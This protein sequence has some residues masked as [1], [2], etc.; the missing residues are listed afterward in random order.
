MDGAGR[1]GASGGDPV[2]G[3]EGLMAV[4]R[5]YLIRNYL[6]Y[7][8]GKRQSLEPGRTGPAIVDVLRRTRH[9]LALRQRPRRRDMAAPVDRDR[10]NRPRQRVP[11]AVSRSDDITIGI[12]QVQAL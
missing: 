12:T 1:T 6:A 3:A 5:Q 2:A 11:N 4:Q 8:E 10:P 7:S 9:R